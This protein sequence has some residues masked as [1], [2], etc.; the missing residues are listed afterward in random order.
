MPARHA[1]ATDAGA[2]GVQGRGQ[3][4]VCCP[5]TAAPAIRQP[6]CAFGGA[7]PRDSQPLLH[8]GFSGFRVGDLALSD[9]FCS[10]R[11]T[12][13]FRT[14][15][16]EDLVRFVLDSAATEDYANNTDTRNF[17]FLCIAIRESFLR[18]RKFLSRH[19]R[20]FLCT[21]LTRGQQRG[22]DPSAFF[23]YHVTVG[24]GHFGDQSMPAQ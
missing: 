8:F 5:E 11:R 15:F 2:S 22:D 19:C 10:P 21:C 18:L 13:R 1:E 23:R 20:E 17:C 9:C 16:I 7:P 12:R 3:K 14:C 4:F 6:C 24:L